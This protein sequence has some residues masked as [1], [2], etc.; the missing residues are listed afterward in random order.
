MVGCPYQYDKTRPTMCKTLKFVKTIVENSDS[1]T[2]MVTK[3]C[4]QPKMTINYLEAIRETL[5][6]YKKKHAMG[7]CCCS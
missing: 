7:D 2:F 6:R 4:K 3:K 5:S 1:V